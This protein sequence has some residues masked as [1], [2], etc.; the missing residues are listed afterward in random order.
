MRKE[1]LFGALFAV[2]ILFSGI[3]L[4]NYSTSTAYSPQPAT[5]LDVPTKTLQIEVPAVSLPPDAILNKWNVPSGATYNK[6]TA[7]ATHDGDTSYLLSKINNDHQT[8]NFET[9]D[10]PSETII[11]KIVVTATAKKTG[12]APQASKMSS[13]IAVGTTFSDLP[14]GGTSISTSY[15]AY[16]RDVTKNPFTNTPFTLAEVETWQT[17]GLPITFGMAQNTDSKEVRVT[18]NSMKIDFQDNTAPATTVGTCAVPGNLGWCIGGLVEHLTAVDPQPGAGVKEIRYTLNPGGTEQIYQAP[19]NSVTATTD[20]SISQTGIYSLTYYAIDSVNNVEAPNTLNDIKLDVSMPVTTPLINGAAPTGGLYT[21]GAQ[22]TLTCNDVGSGVDK[23][24]FTLNGSQV[25]TYTSAIIVTQGGTNT[26]TFYCTDI[27]GNSESVQTLNVEIIQATVS[28]NSPSSVMWGDQSTINGGTQYTAPDSDKVS[29]NWGDGTTA[30][31]VNINQ[32][33]TW[34][35]THTYGPGTAPQRTIQAQVVNSQSV[36]ISDTAS[37]NITILKRPT[38]ITLDDVVDPLQ[39]GSLYI[40]GNL[41]DGITGAGVLPGRTITFSSDPLIAIE[42]ATTG[43]IKV[44][45]SSPIS[46][47]TACG[48]TSDKSII[49]NDGAEITVPGKPTDMTFTFCDTVG[50]FEYLVTDGT[51]FTSTQYP[52]ANPQSADGVTTV[53]ISNLGTGSVEITSVEG[54]NAGGQQLFATGFDITNADLSSDGK[55]LTLNDGIFATTGTAPSVDGTTGSIGAKLIN[56]ADYLNSSTANDDYTVQYSPGGIGA[57]VAVVADVGDLI[58]FAPCTDLDADGICD[59]YEIN[60]V[61]YA[62]ST[63]TCR[64]TLPDLPVVGEDDVY[65]EIDG[66][67]GKVNSAA[68]AAVDAKFS[69]VHLGQTQQSDLHY[70]LSDIN[71][72]EP[73]S[74]NPYVMNVWRDTDTN[75]LNDYDSRKADNFG[76]VADRVTFTGTQVNAKVSNTAVSFSG[77]SITT[78]G[79]GTYS[80]DNKVYGTINLKMI[81]TLSGSPTSISQSSASCTGQASELTLSPITSTITNGGT[82]SQKKITTKIQFSTNGP[83][84]NGSIGTCTVNLTIGGQTVSSVANENVSPVILTEKQI[85]KLKGGYRY[86]FFGESIGGPTGR[87]EVWGNDAIIALSA[88]TNGVG[89]QDEQAGTF[90]HELGH[91]L[92][93]DHGG[94]RW[95]QPNTQVN[96]AVLGQSSINCKPNYISVLPYHRQLPGTYLNQASVG[97]AGGWQLD[98]SSGLL[99][100]LDEL[101]LNEDNGLISNAAAGSPIPRLVWGTPGVSPYYKG[102]AG[103]ITLG[104]PPSPA[105]L[106][107]NISWDGDATTNESFVNERKDINNF[108]IFGCMASTNTILSDGNDWANLDYRIGVNTVG[109]F[110]DG[111]SVDELNEEQLQQIELASANYVIIPPPAVDGTETR[112]KGSQLPIKIR[113]Q[114][115]AGEDITYATIRAEYYTNLDPTIKTIGSATYSSTL[116]HYQIPWKTPKVAAVYYVNVYVENPIPSDPDRLLTHPTNPLLDNTNTPITIRVILA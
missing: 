5:I 90:M 79:G 64:L 9:I 72:A 58:S 97:G 17:G 26:V 16:D 114:N 80:S 60:G 11:K 21:P 33:G 55:T 66:F 74:P 68:I 23:I 56:D 104:G 39:G 3:L 42:T 82:S 94:A 20:V 69:E 46:T 2:L 44:I 27:A 29:I 12:P 54:S 106:A 32:D 4:I 59:D 93:L 57:N 110:G 61:P 95:L 7:V 30:D 108:G 105:S 83:I 71:I 89:S 37:A 19:P 1:V 52:P 22:V 49:V 91:L 76:E 35:A 112:N 113:L 78:P 8:F 62:C 73:T 48:A 6:I 45:N 36:V 100:N 47:G 10:F 13:T 63:G 51:G 14:L 109:T 18:K 85:A 96:P 116:G 103:L 77:I 34:T 75:R 84:T 31:E 65:V 41:K 99:G 43:Q 24:F 115:Q 81:I 38:V 53:T 67:A 50:T 102:G 107:T 40:H 101:N 98:Y 111:L 15:T 92:N 87:A 88:Y 28:I 70:I 25:S 86:V